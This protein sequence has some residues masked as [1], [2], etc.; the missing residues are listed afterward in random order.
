MRILVLSFMALLLFSSLSR[1]LS[2][3]SEVDEG[4]SSLEKLESKSEHTLTST[5]DHI[6][7]E[8][9]DEED[10]DDD[11]EFMEHPRADPDEWDYQDPYRHS[12]PW[13]SL[14]SSVVKVKLYPLDDIGVV[15]II[16]YVIY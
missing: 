1:T 4:L 14:C 9:Y 6:N 15:L 3:P 12:P 2:K 13:W 16:Q 11:E 7:D 10:E 8:L 5:L